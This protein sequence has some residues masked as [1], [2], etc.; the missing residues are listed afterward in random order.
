MGAGVRVS[1]VARWRSPRKDNK[2]ARITKSISS[3]VYPTASR[4][5]PRN[6]CGVRPDTIPIPDAAF[7]K[8]QAAD[9]RGKWPDALALARHHLRR[10]GFLH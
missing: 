8:L 10:D 3:S 7:D 6:L 1:D 2:S 5:L 4:K 9:C